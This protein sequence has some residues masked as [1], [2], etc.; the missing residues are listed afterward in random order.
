[1]LTIREAV[2]SDVPALQEL[3]LRHLTHYPPEGE[4]DTAAWEALLARLI[5]YP[6]HYLLVGTLDGRPVSSVTLVVIP[7]LTHNLR[8]YAVMENVVTHADFRAQGYASA[9][10]ERASVIA[11][12]RGCYKI[13]L[14]TGSKKESTLRFYEQNGFDRHAKTAFLKRFE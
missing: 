7:N 14:L 9:L 13:M 3:Y 11:R 12:E 8:P 5:E 6:D 1:V 4:P 10:I 2:L